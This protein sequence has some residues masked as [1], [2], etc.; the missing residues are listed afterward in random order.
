MSRRGRNFLI[1]AAAVLLAGVLIVLLNR[2]TGDFSAKYEGTDLRADVT[3]ISRGN[4]YEDYIARYQN[5]PAVSEKIQVDISTMTGNGRME[6]NG[7]YT[8]D[9]S[10]VT[11]IVQVPQEGLYHIQ[12][13]YLTVESRGVDVERELYINGEL[14]F[15]GSPFS[16]VP[17]SPWGS[18]APS[19]PSGK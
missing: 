9:D 14:P 3:G 8:A 17:S 19:I 6:E 5:L 4:T 18:M 11:W 15:S 16:S 12:M 7:V 13:D 1:A 10:E 2:G